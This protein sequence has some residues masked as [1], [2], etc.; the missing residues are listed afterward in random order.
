MNKPNSFD[1]H[2]NTQHRIAEV[3]AM[4]T[5]IPPR[6]ADLEDKDRR[7]YVSAPGSVHLALQTEAHQRGTDLWT[8]GGAVLSQWVRLGCPDQLSANTGS[9]ASTPSPSPSV[10]NQKEPAAAEGQG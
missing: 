6:Q 1:L 5:A 9:F 3:T 4:T 7:F 8:L 10:A 2:S